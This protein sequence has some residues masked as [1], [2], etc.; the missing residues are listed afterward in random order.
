MLPLT[1]TDQEGEPD[2]ILWGLGAVCYGP[3]SVKFTVHSADGPPAAGVSGSSV[4]VE[5]SP[6]ERL[7]KVR[8]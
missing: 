6:G 8:C 3:L 7:V 1:G 5:G 4:V 2:R